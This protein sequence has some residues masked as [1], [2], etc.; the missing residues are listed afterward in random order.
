MQKAE[1]EVLEGL[2]ICYEH[3][4]GKGKGFSLF[5]LILLTLLFLV[6][7]L[8]WGRYS[9][10]RR[11]QSFERPVM[12]MGGIGSP[13]GEAWIKQT[14]IQSLVLALMVHFLFW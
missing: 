14:N 13:C 7:S 6:H 10:Y 4:G 5:L 11:H 8:A 1:K 3:K 9:P 12:R 2:K